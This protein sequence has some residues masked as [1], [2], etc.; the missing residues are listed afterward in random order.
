M[1]CFGKYNK[2]IPQSSKVINTIGSALIKVNKFEEALKFLRKA[3]ELD[4]ANY[5]SYLNLGHIF[6]ERKLHN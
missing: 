3:I 6:K 1:E 2:F 4:P 5:S